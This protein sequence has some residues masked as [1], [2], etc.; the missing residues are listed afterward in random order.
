MK[1]ISI[2][3]CTFA[4]LMTLA[5]CKDAK[6]DISDGKTKL[7][8]FD[9]AS[10]TK[11]D[12]YSILKSNSSSAVLNLIQKQ[13]YDAENIKITNDMKKEAQKS[14][15]EIKK[16]YKNNKE[17]ESALNSA[18]MKN[19]KEY[20]EKIAYPAQQ[21]TALIKKYATDNKDDIFQKYHPVK[22][23]IIKCDKKE[24]ADKAL[25]A[26]KDKQNI[27]DVAKKYG[28]A[29]DT[30]NGKE[31]IVFA[32]SG[33]SQ[34]VY[35]KV[36]KTSKAGLINEVIADEATSSYYVVDV[37]SVDPKSYSEEAI[38]AISSG[39]FDIKNAMLEFYAK[40]YKLSIYD[41]DTY[42][43]LNNS[44]PNLIKK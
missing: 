3:L 13:L 7:V 36:S 35:D 34:V 16:S 19:E 40:K 1:K 39:A 25:K 41:I 10:V 42:N 28:K 32:N 9:G 22:A 17:F 6:A 27:S 26:L 33:I 4:M 29:G 37:K 11:E 21:Q 43:Q 38:D 30:L 20:L 23:S 14:L 5:G 15:D 12:V 44:N 18:G 8:S 2:L 24:N 31:Q